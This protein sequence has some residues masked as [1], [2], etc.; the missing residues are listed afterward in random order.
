LSATTFD[1]AV[2]FLV[3]AD[4]LALICPYPAKHAVAVIFAAM[5]AIL[6]IRLRLRRGCYGFIFVF[7]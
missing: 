3:A 7:A 5:P 1:G 2:T 4:G 6:L